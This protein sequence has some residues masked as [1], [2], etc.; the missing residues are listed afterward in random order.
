MKSVLGLNILHVSPSCLEQRTSVTKLPAHTA[1]KFLK[2]KSFK[3]TI[4]HKL[5]LLQSEFL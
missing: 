1:T 2:L 5:D 3:T 4:V